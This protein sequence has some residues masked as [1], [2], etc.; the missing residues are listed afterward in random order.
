[1]YVKRDITEQFNKLSTVYNML[2][3]IGP[4]QAGKTTFL[5]EQ[6]IEINGS[7]VLFDDP[8]ALAM[9]DE[10][11][12]KFENQYIRS[13]DQIVLDEVQYGKDAGKKL[14]YLAENKW[15]IWVTSSSQTLLSTDVLSWLVGRISIIR[16]YPF[17]LSEFLRARNLHEVTPAILRRSIWEHVV[18]GGYPKVIITEDFE[19]KKIILRD[20][21]ETMVLK[22][23][24]KTFAIQ[25]IKS[26][27]VFCHY[28]SNSVGNVIIYD[29]ICNEM[30]LSFQTI[31][32][33]LDAM[34]KS[35][36]I[37]RIQPF[38][39][40]KLKEIV[41]QPKMYFI[42][43]GLRN[44]IANEFPL[45]LDNKGKLFENYVLTE[46]LKL[47]LTVKY[48]LTKTQLEVDFIIEKDGEVIPIE[49]K[50]STTSEKIER[51]LRSFIE[52]YKPKKAIVVFYDGIE[53]EMVVDECRVIFTSVSTILKKI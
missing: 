12:K 49:V 3:I 16:L 22:D 14:K 5:R 32:K 25:D 31:K 46:L 6:L 45:T 10:D 23:I 15:H 29:K 43:A 47:G 19:L 28:L 24:A 13:Y 30:A 20:L 9:F 53:K 18:Y 1:M 4:R 41:K 21:Y 8:D 37:I 38:Y 34:E 44:A 27:E 36:F 42:D 40:N 48:W 51:S 33:Y 26:L 52:T 39:T 50:L 7:Y 2:A 35:Y 11:I 17:S